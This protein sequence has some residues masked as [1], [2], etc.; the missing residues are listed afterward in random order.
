MSKFR[1]SSFPLITCVLITASFNLS[2]RPHRTGMM[3]NGNFVPPG[4]ITSCQIC[5]VSP[6]GGARNSFGLSA[7]QFVTVNGFEQFWPSVFNLDSDGDGAS[8]GLELGDPTGT[9]VA[10]RT[11]GL[12]APGDATSTPD[13]PNQAPSITST[14]PVG[15]TIGTLYQYQVA[16]SDPESG[17][18]TFALLSPPAWLSISTD[19]LI[20]G[21]PPDD[22]A[23]V[24]SINVRVT[25]NGAP[26]E[27]AQQTYSLTIAASFDGWK[28]LHFNLPTEDALASPSADPDNDGIP[29]LHEYA[30]RL[31]PRV[32]DA[33]TASPLGFAGPGQVTFTLDVRDDDPA[34]SVL[35]EFSSTLP[36]SSVTTIT[37]TETDPTPG[38]GMKR[39]TFTDTASNQLTRFIRLKVTR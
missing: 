13:L 16:A 7:E 8:N 15:G 31:N 35:S 2:A 23:R 19:G 22:Q 28:N 4:A 9:G 20:S 14:A 38:D 25:D 10:Q 18:L 21:T 34:L 17:A 5:H 24:H 33:F 1:F 39:L 27:A 30:T 11:T 37:P 12:S 36:F 29:N 3:P 6:V 32:H 26:P